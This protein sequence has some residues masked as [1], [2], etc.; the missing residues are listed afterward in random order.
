[1]QNNKHRIGQWIVVASLSYQIS[2]L[3]GFPP[4]WRSGPI[5]G[6]RWHFRL[7]TSRKRDR[8][9]DRPLF[10]RYGIWALQSPAK[11][12]E[13]HDRWSY[14]KKKDE[15][16]YC[17]FF[18]KLF[19]ILIIYHDVVLHHVP[20]SRPQHHHRYLVQ[21]WCSGQLISNSQEDVVKALKLISPWWAMAIIK[22]HLTI[23]SYKKISYT[24]ISH[25]YY[26]E[27]FFLSLLLWDI[28]IYISAL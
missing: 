28:D 3:I 14:G 24:Q 11:G 15:L 16:A 12:R 22:I 17:T 8:N 19:L 4:T 20:S 13:F 21:S 26:T 1:M 7:W 6:L 23:T 9:P 25:W 27:G 5:D 10:V 2:V 18:T